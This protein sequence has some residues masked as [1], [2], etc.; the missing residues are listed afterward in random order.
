MGVA[1]THRDKAAKLAKS[2]IDELKKR[3]HTLFTHPKKLTKDEWPWL[4]EIFEDHPILGRGWEAKNR[5]LNIFPE[6][7]PM[8]RSKKAREA[9]QAKRAALP[10]SEQESGRGLDEW[11]AFIKKDKKLQPFFESPVGMI[12]DWGE[13]IIRIGTTGYSNAGTEPK[14]RYLRML[15]AISRGLRFK[16]L[17]ARLLWADDHRRTDRWP[18]F[19][20][21]VKGKMTMKRF[22]ELANAFI[23]RKEPRSTPTP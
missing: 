8:G 11:V 15:A 7:P 22:V 12:R 16:M 20:D 21:D 3:K 19:C 4:K 23:A 10:M 6:K 14:N 9:A 13:E 5:G 17:R 2:R 1:P 18:S